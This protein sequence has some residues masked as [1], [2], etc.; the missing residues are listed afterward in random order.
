MTPEERRLITSLFDRLRSFGRPE[1][2]K[3]AEALINQSGRAIPDVPY[4]LV[5][6]TLI[7][8]QALEAANTRLQ[9]AEER[10]RELEE[11]L[12]RRPSG[13]GAGAVRPSLP[14]M[15]RAPMAANLLGRGALHNPRQQLRPL[16]AVSCI[17]R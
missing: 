11:E 7:Q 13:S 17:L 3:Q 2:D 10:V 12:Q 4:M 15:S 6:S 8:E 5:Q 16:R 1:K 9:E 14:R